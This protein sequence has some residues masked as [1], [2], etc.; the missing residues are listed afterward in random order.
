MAT[1]NWQV[2]E[3][4]SIYWNFACCQ[5]HWQLR[6]RASWEGPEGYMYQVSQ[7]LANLDEEPSPKAESPY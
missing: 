3:V 4:A 6:G 2:R 5:Y 1:K 7:A